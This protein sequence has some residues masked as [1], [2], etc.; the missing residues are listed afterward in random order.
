M[1]RHTAV[2]ERVTHS[3]A[4]VTSSTTTVLAANVGRIAALIVNDGTSTVWLR[5]DGGTA[6][7]NEGIPLGANGGS[8]Y[9]VGIYDNID[10]DK[11]AISGITASATVVVTVTEWD[12]F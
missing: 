8:Y 10:A 9:M 6:V 4:S 11:G 3:T 2:S 5:L 12:N 7:A 1:A